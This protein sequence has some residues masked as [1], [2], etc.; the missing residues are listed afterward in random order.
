METFERLKFVFTGIGTLVGIGL[1]LTL[2]GLF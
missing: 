2:G 1:L